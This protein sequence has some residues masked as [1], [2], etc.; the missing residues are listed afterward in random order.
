[1]EPAVNLE[2]PT[3]S[4]KRTEKTKH[5]LNY[6]DDEDDDDDDEF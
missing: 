2:G 5:G 6:D 4:S 3:H 1:M